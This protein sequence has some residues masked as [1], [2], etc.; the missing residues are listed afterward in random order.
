VRQNGHSR[1]RHLQ[2]IAQRVNEVQAVLAAEGLGAV[3]V[4]GVLCFAQ[5]TA[6]CPVDRVI[7][8]AHGVLV[9]HP[10]AVAALAAEG[11]TWN[12]DAVALLYATLARHFGVPGETGHGRPVAAPQRQTVRPARRRRSLTRQ[13][14]LEVLPLVLALTL[15]CAMVH[16][17]AT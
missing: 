17:L 15:L 7:P 4:R 16:S 2:T 11:G 3:A 12:G 13:V 14:L 10:E 1:A 8:T 5:E 6:A 9:G